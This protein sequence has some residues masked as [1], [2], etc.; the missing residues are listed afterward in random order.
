MSQA[1][2]G[3][4][5]AALARGSAN[6]RQGTLNQVVRYEGM[7]VT[8]ATAI[9]LAAAREQCWSA[10]A[11]AVTLTAAAGHEP[12]FVVG[13]ALAYETLA[14]MEQRKGGIIPAPSSLRQ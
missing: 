11:E 14:E 7:A 3:A 2:D 6:R 4:V 9:E 13:I 8:R 12:D 5:F 1:T 10:I